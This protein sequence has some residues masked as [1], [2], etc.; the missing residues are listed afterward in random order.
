MH[1]IKYTDLSIWNRVFIFFRESKLNISWWHKKKSL[2]SAPLLPISS[3]KLDRGI[4]S[5]PKRLPAISQR[6]PGSQLTLCLGFVLVW[7][8][9]LRFSPKFGFPPSCLSCYFY[10]SSTWTVHHEKNLRDLHKISGKQL[11]SHFFC[12]LHTN[13]TYRLISVRNSI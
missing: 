3:C 10:L 12:C 4:G 5:I 8:A 9:L 7:K 1:Y 2:F 11:L 13:L 6:H